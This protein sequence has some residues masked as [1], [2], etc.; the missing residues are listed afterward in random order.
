M[1]S[2]QIVDIIIKAEDQASAAA[3][4]VDKS[5]QKIKSSTSSFASVP[6]FDTLKTKL[7]SVAESID[8]KFGGALTKAKG[9]LTSFRERITSVGS[10]LTTGIGG[11]VDKVRGKLESLGA[12]AKQAGNSLGFLKSAASMAVGMIGFELVSGLV[13]AARASINATSQLDYF[14]SR[15]NMTAQQSSQFKSELNDLQKEFRK[16]DMTSVGATAEDLA[17]RYQLPVDKLG[18]LTRMT[19]VM[20]SEFVRNGRSQE[21][22]VLAVADAMDGQFKRLQE[23]G[24]SQNTL[25]KNG[26]NGDLEDKK[27]LIDA[28]NKSMEEMGYD[29][30]AKDITNLDDAWQ[31]LTIAGGQLL[32]KVL[33]PIT[34]AIIS[35]VEGL[36]SVADGFD[37]VVKF[38]SDNGWAQGIVLIGGITV[39]LAL[40]AGALSIAAAAEGGLM[41]LMPGFIT[42]LAAVAAEFLAISIAGA[43]LWAIL[44]A[45]ALI[46]V[47]VYEVGIAFGWWTDV[48]S[49]LDAIWSGL[50]RMWD[51]FVNHPDVQAVFKGI[52][53]G[54]QMLWD[55]I[56][57]AGQAVMDFL[58]ISSDSKFDV[59][60]EIIMALGV[61]WSALTM[62]IRT[63][64]FVL[65]ELWN[66]V[67]MLYEEVLEPFGEW[68]GETLAP[69]FEFIGEVIAAVL[70]YV[71]GLVDAFTLFSNGQMSLPDLVM[72]VMTG[73]WNIYTTILTMIVNAVVNWA[74]Q[75]VSRALSAGSGFVNGIVQWISQLPGRV[76][77]FMSSALSMIISI[78]GQWVSNAVSKASSLVSQVA[79]TLS[80][81]PGRI[82]SALSGVVNAIV[83]PFQDAY[84]RVAEEVD[85]I[86][87]KASE[88]SG[89]AFGGETAYAG[90]GLLT[91][92]YSIGES[93]I[94][95][96]V[97]EHI[98]LDLENVPAHIDTNTLINMLS[99]RN[100]LRALTGNRTFQD[101]DSQVKNEILRKS[102]R[103]N[104][105]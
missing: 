66:A 88:V 96:D 55:W 97:N 44:G 72:A 70:P 52:S 53:Q 41:A 18:D 25:M 81:L 11:A 36:I 27:S 2:Q 42:S 76:S 95:V 71:Q 82:S 67:S 40:F 101:L 91:S 22:A 39:G 73:L 31:A 54:A 84:N 60:H 23:I 29:K 6:G 21:D 24:I 15:L 83:K 65:Q 79:S 16:V 48:G 10:T 75:M 100:V 85:K 80:G 50:Q 49:M 45:L 86:K 87:N 93:S 89:I 7:T 43:P 103:A 20:S 62:P 33:V 30:T 92:D 74:S 5:L 64:I 56:Q 77:S 13:E 78:A 4:K 102:L 98:T 63:V 28:L 94:S 46:A 35:I 26:W 69:V 59:V 104:G 51:A 1:V 61:A 99:D 37:A 8:T 38:L 9:Y 58:N 19:A 3:D 57:Q 90:E 105:G 34:P 47:A 14:A 32:Q 68:L 17:A 12:S